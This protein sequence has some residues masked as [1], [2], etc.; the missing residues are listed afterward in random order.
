M[1]RYIIKTYRAVEDIRQT[2]K[3]DIR[4]QGRFIFFLII[5]STSI[6][7]NLA[8]SFSFFLFHFSFFFFLIAQD[9]YHVCADL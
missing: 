6:F 2:T 4:I 8:F 9:I 1:S 3:D 7:F 5:V